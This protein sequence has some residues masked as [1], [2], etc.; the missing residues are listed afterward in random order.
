VS[1][2]PK[3]KTCEFYRQDEDSTYCGVCLFRLPPGVR[4]GMNIVQENINT[5]DLHKPKEVQP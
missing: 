3:C 2:K 5:C 1:D 4:T